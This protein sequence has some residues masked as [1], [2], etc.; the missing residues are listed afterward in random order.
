M[1]L[2][3]YAV[4]NQQ[5]DHRIQSANKTNVSLKT[6]NTGYQ[7][8]YF[9]MHIFGSEARIEYGSW[10]RR[11]G[12]KWRNAAESG[13]KQRNASFRNCAFS[14]KWRNAI[15]F[16]N[17]LL[18]SSVLQ[19]TAISVLNSS[20]REYQSNRI[21]ISA[22][23]SATIGLKWDYQVQVIEVILLIMYPISNKKVKLI[24]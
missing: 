4:V 10:K 9:L 5:P 22:T 13:G 16:Y 3:I 21:C 1:N 24:S 6:S 20:G 11:K 12:G 14:R 19:K 17:F 8:S 23:I 18:F 2:K 7:L 15:Y